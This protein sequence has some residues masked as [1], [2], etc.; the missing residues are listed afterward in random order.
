MREVKLTKNEHMRFIQRMDAILAERGMTM[1]ELATR[2]GVSER[3]IY[4]FRNDTTRDPSKFLASKLANALGMM[5]KD[6]RF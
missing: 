2:I 3:S 5:P 4:N 6:W 1:K